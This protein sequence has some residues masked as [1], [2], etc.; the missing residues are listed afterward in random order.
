MNVFNKCFILFFISA[1]A[2]AQI[3][4]AEQNAL[5]DV[6]RFTRGD[7]WTVV[8]NLNEDVTTW[9]GVTIENDK[10]IGLDL[11]ANNLEG[12]LPSSLSNLTYLE[13]L[14]LSENTLS[15]EIPDA[16]G[17]LGKLEVL[18]LNGNELSGEIPSDLYKLKGIKKMKLADNS[19]E[20]LAANYE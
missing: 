2:F 20:V 4:K 9:K 6:Y 7:S 16:L 15:G 17:D 5:E 8:W 3:S 12:E 14:D 13:R 11:R 19:F 1:S 10:V 18:V